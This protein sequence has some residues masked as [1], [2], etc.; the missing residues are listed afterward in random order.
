MSYQEVTSTLLDCV[1]VAGEAAEQF[2]DE[3]HDYIGAVGATKSMTTVLKACAICFDWDWLRCHA[4]KENHL[5]AFLAVNRYLAPLL[6]QTEW[7]DPVE[8]PYVEQSW[9]NDRHMAR[10][11]QVMM[12]RVRNAV[13]NGRRDWL[14]ITGKVTVK[15][16]LFPALLHMTVTKVFSQHL[17]M[18]R[19]WLG[20][21]YYACTVAS[22]LSVLAT[23][24]VAFAHPSTGVVFET[25]RDNLVRLGHGRRYKRSRYGRKTRWTFTGRAFGL[26][27]LSEA[28]NAGKQVILCAD[29]V[30]LSARRV[31]M[32]FYTEKARKQRAYRSSLCVF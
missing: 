17:G 13:Q 26:A 3:L 12:S 11:Y 22:E 23:L 8:F 7:P 10:Q 15:P 19:K 18:T 24:T 5:Q 20:R 14:E 4:P 9:P 31:E 30:T 1:H 16:L 32:A 27:S 29:I 2:A 28:P 21:D 6:V 25:K